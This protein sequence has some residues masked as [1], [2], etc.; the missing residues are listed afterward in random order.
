MGVDFASSTQWNEDRQKYLY[1][2]NR[3]GFENSPD[4]QI[5]FV[6]NIIIEK[7]KLIYAE[8]A[9][10]EEAFD[11]MAELT[12]KSFQIHLLLVTILLVTN[13]EYPKQG[14]SKIKVL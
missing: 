5:D 12:A 13:T 10:H 3:A 9:V 8:D 2:Y 1:E 7:Y 14:N 11:D 4:Q 6:C